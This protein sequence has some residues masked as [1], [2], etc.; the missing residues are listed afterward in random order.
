MQVHAKTNKRKL[1]LTAKTNIKAG[2]YLSVTLSGGSGNGA[3]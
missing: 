1:G 2:Y 3:S